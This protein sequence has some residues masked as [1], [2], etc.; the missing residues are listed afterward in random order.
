MGEWKVLMGLGNPGDRYQNTRHNAG[1]MALAQLAGNCGFQDPR[2]FKQNLVTYGKV[3]GH[4]VILAWP[5]TYMNLSGIAAAELLNYYKLSLED[6]LVIHDDM[7]LPVGRLK[8]GNGG[9]SGGHNGLNSIFTELGDAFDRLRVGIGRPD[10]NSFMGD[11][12][13][14]VLAPFTSLEWEEIDRALLLAAKSASAWVLNGL[15]ACQRR[16]NV[17]P[18]APKKAKEKSEDDQD[19]KEQQDKEQAPNGEQASNGEHAKA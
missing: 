15:A 1:F 9:G 10:K 3:E 5:Q 12:A 16:A 18:K 13:S 8:A 11:Y 17:R 4:K 14:Y 2:R 6:L 7:E 19:K